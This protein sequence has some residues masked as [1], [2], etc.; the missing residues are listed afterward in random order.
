MEQPRTTG[1]K[2]NRDFKILWLGDMGSELGSAMSMLVFPLFGYALSHSTTQAA[3]ATTAFFAAGTILRLPAGALVDRWSRR[4]VLL[5]S[6]LAS[7]LVFGVLAVLVATGSASVALLVVAAVLAGAVE[8]FFSPAASASLRAVVA[9]VD[10]AQAYTR[11][12]ARHH[13]AA[14]IGPPLGGALFAVAASLPFALDAASFAAFSVAVL[15][16]R[17]RLPAPARTGARRLRAD[18]LEG[19]RFLWSQPA[20]RAMMLWGGILNFAMGYVLILITLRLVRAGVHPAAIGA[21]DAIAAGAGILGAVVASRYAQR[22]PTGATTMTT[23]LVLAAVVVPM[24]WTTDVRLIGAL[25]ALGTFLLPANNAGIGAYLSFVTPD[26]MQGRMNSAADFVSSGLTPLA[27]VVAGALLATIG[28][29][30]GTLAGA[31]LVAVSLVPL[32]L[33]TSVRRLGRPSE[34]ASP[35]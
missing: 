33:E 34:W 16:L 22:L 21:V 25:L 30:T 20:A 13:V 10:L 4:R 17:A 28:G 18:V 26:E 23:G 8:T 5:L 15:F 2:G 6:N 7:A 32:L 1:L 12:Q 19:M 9:P 27:P 31:A 3:L 14:L 29:T 35:P 11:M 24:A